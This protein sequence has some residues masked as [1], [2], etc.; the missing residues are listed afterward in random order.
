MYNMAIGGTFGSQLAQQQQLA[1][2]RQGTRLSRTQ[3]LIAQRPTYTYTTTTTTYTVEQQIQDNLISYDKTI[4]DARAR[5]ESLR[6][7]YRRDRKRGKSSDKQYERVRKA[8]IYLDDLINNRTKVEQGY[9]LGGVLHYASDQTRATMQSR[10]A[11]DR[12]QS[13]VKAGKYDLQKVGLK[14]GATQQQYSQAVKEY[15]QNVAYQNQL[16]SWTDKVGFE[17][18]PEPIKEEMKKRGL[19]TEVVETKEVPAQKISIPKVGESQIMDRIRAEQERE[20]TNYPISSSPILSKIYKEQ[21]ISAEG[22]ITFTKYKNIYAPTKIKYPS[23][24]PISTQ[25]LLEKIRIGYNEA[26]AR[27]SKN[28]KSSSKGI[29]DFEGKTYEESY[30]EMEKNLYETQIQG[31]KIEKRLKITPATPI[32]WIQSKIPKV[33]GK[34]VPKF[35]YE[36]IRGEVEYKQEHPLTFIATTVAFAGVYAGLSQVTRG[37]SVL[38]QKTGISA[39]LSSQKAITL[40]QFAMAKVSPAQLWTGTKLVAG[41]GITS[42]YGKNV[43]ERV[44][45]VEEGT[46]SYAFGRIIGSEIEPMMLGGYIGAK[47]EKEFIGYLRTR[48]RIEIPLKRVVPSDVDVV[49]GKNIFP[50]AP[51][52]LHYKLFM[53]QSQRTPALR[54]EGYTG[55]GKLVYSEEVPVKMP[56]MIWH[57]TPEQFWKS[58]KGFTVRYTP[59]M[60]SSEFEALFGAHGVSPH[61][62]GTEFKYKP[63]SLD[64]LP[65]STRPATAV[66]IPAKWKTGLPTKEWELGTAL[67]PMNKKEVQA[68]L[69]IGTVNMPIQS[70][71]EKGFFY[72]IHG[73]GVP[74]DIFQAQ[75]GKSTE[76]V[77][78][79]ILPPKSSYI[80]STISGI[81]PSSISSRAL[82]SKISSILYP[83]S[84]V[85]SKV[86]SR[87]S[88]PKSKIS[89]SIKSII[90]QA[91]SKISLPRSSKISK[92]SSNISRISEMISRIEMSSITKTPPS[93]PFRMP[94][95]E[96]GLKGKI[97]SKVKHRKTPDIYGLF[98]SFTA[99]AVGLEPVKFKSVNQAMKE[100]M[101]I[102]TPFEVGRGGRMANYKPVDEKSLM[103]GIM[104]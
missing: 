88:Y 80:P 14:E 56:S 16:L 39:I 76:T 3:R 61:F 32:L 30:A 40:P 17:K 89:S 12:F 83:S 27:A 57:Q 45:K 23:F 43:Y 84:K 64:I 74:I 69:K 28:V 71:A 18:L 19:V 24:I 73:V 86:S 1:Q 101:R 21:G 52:K 35:I 5:A 36:T 79:I 98:P 55:K 58:G 104:K 50:E 95:I 75:A 70:V 81:S 85:S 87:V 42:L 51:K 92:P 15:N 93:K 25:E 72:K 103:M 100:I 47:A 34:A 41:A 99:R 4:A 6:E 38:A 67:I 65:V 29:I 11:Q 77:M 68:L 59:S 66:I 54:L 63:I 46:R 44:M 82:Y 37:I 62:L 102:K 97:K 10:E 48:E 33:I 22:D 9:E 31:D 78:K 96:T 60:K 49:G 7:K 26:E 13:D 53:E 90:S 91:S 2:Q 20:V 94:P 8:E